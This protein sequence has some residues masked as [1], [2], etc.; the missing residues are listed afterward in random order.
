MKD[1][2]L[3]SRRP[4]VRRVL[5]GLAAG[6][7]LLII[8]VAGIVMV[9]RRSSGNKE[10][11]GFVLDHRGQWICEGQSGK[12]LKLGEE[13]F[14]GRVILPENA[15][16]KAWITI[17]LRDGTTVTY[18]T[19]TELPRVEQ[20]GLS[21]RLFDRLQ[22][23]YFALAAETLSRGQSDSK[24]LVDAVVPLNGQQLEL[25][26]AVASLAPGSYAIQLDAIRTDAD[27]LLH[28]PDMKPDREKMLDLA[29]KA[30]KPANVPAGA[31]TPGLYQLTLFV[32]PD[33]DAFVGQCWILV[34]TSADFGRLKGLYREAAHRFDG[35][36]PQR[37]DEGDAS[38]CRWKFLRVLLSCL[39]ENGEDPK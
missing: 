37:V 12:H 22:H 35:K 21:K 32:D 14:A 29:V 17:N 36:Q 18:D 27:G 11:A 10:A 33:S 34:A 28:V 9:Q 7:L 16:E 5:W 15:D 25:A 39:T 30:G 24:G 4:T 3:V 20:R 31:V 6:V 2:P 13:V 19:R 1:H 26:D 8:I 38:G 23:R